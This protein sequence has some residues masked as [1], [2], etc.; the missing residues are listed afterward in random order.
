MEVPKVEAQGR[1]L[2]L[3]AVQSS[4]PPPYDR[5]ALSSSPYHFDSGRTSAPKFYEVVQLPF[6]PSY[7]PGNRNL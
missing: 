1:F 6:P 5:V 4:F 3:D 2:A 7:D